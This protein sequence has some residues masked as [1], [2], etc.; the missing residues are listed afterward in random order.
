M[1]YMTYLLF[2]QWT[3]LFLHQNNFSHSYLS[4]F[5]FGEI[6][7]LL[8]NKHINWSFIKHCSMICG[9]FLRFQFNVILML[10][11]HLLANLSLGWYF[12]VHLHCHIIFHLFPYENSLLARSYIK[13][14]NGILYLILYEGSG[15]LSQISNDWQNFSIMLENEE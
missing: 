1:N 6:E 2:M 11:K 5:H 14:T 8:A 13:I 4:Y 15:R 12:S 3:K 9:P 7:V 10:E